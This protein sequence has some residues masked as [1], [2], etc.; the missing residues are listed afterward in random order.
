MKFS[1]NWLKKWISS[2]LDCNQIANILTM[3]GLEVELIEKLDNF[4][5]IV[6]GHVIEVEN[7]NNADKL[8]V[9]KVDIGGDKTIQIVC[10]ANNVKPNIKVPCALIG[11]K[12][13]N[14]LKITKTNLRGVES[15]GMLCSSDE[16]GFGKSDGLL[17][18]PNDAPIGDNIIKYLELDDYA[19]TT[20]ITPNR[21]DCLSIKGIAREIAAITD[22]K[23]NEID[24]I[25]NKID[26]N[27]IIPTKIQ[28]PN[29]CKKFYTR[30]IKNI[31][32]KIS[33]PIWITQRLQKSNIKSINFLVD[34]TN[35]I[36]IE[37]GQPM[38]VYDLDKI[39]EYIKVRLA[40]KGEKLLCLN[41]KQITLDNDTLIIADKTKVLSLA[42]IM[43]GKSSS[44]N[45]ETKNVLIESAFFS[46][47][48]VLGKS[49][50]YG[51][52]SESSYRFERGVD[53][54]LQED[55]IQ[56]ATSLI[57]ENMSNI[58][59]CPLNKINGNTIKSK[60]ISLNLKNVKKILGIEVS[61]EKVY[62]ILKNLNFNPQEN[63]NGFKIISP[64]FRFDI[65]LEI[66]I[67]E[68]IA[69]IF[70][71]DNIKNETPCKKISILNENQQYLTSKIYNTLI[72]KGYNEVINYSFVNNQW[73]K[74]FNNNTNP[75]YLKNPI[76][77]SL[78]VMQSS[79]IGNLIFTLK[80]N[81]N[82][83][84]ER[85]KIFEIATIFYKDCNQNII[86]E[87]HI[88]GLVHGNVLPEQWGMEKEYIDFF[89][90]KNDIALLLNKKNYIFEKSIHPAFHPG[91]SANIIMNNKKIGFIGELH[92]KWIQKYD[93]KNNVLIFELELDNLLKNEKIVYQEISKFQ[94]VIRDIAFIVPKE[95]QY[96][97]LLNTLNEKKDKTIKKINIFDLY[98]GNNIP[99]NMK[100]IAI[101]I[102]FQHNHKTMEI[103]EI[104]EKIN[105]LINQAKKIGAILR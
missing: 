73:E 85:I 48:I 56:R 37:L 12:L 81:L 64:S 32:N 17:I 47:D 83:K 86:Q 75:I 40:T 105:C 58:N 39:D 30:I 95:I 19:I 68:E 4:S 23:I 11:A 38:H 21:S 94:P 45:L 28:E 61:K 99:K 66:D 104:D 18:L 88:G 82:R 63:D 74:D 42:G 26:N 29:L 49:R 6:I 7:H 76:I 35:Y 52:V 91:K 72:N 46:P 93:I 13:P 27:E 90:V 84:H 14:G 24:I 98:E 36:M 43:G 67:I 50:K 103:K 100:S 16:I 22:T 62:K 44:V 80:N 96:Q 8:K 89:N 1:Y 92:P 77:S 5:N 87:K 57:N 78:N 97:Q 41:D 33:T 9:T 59:I 53:F 101:K 15:N 71:Y 25:K 69:R 70:G 3:S 51:I 102:V 31:D 2:N 20:K 55:A 79:L 60:E 65:N 34:I 54:N 10:G